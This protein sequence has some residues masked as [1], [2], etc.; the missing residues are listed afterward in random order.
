MESSVLVIVFILS[1]MYID[2]CS[3][4][5]TKEAIRGFRGAA[6]FRLVIT[7]IGAIVRILHG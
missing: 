1:S 4:G 5:I 2:L 6:V 3:D 7:F